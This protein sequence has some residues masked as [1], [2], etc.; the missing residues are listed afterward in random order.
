M[1]RPKSYFKNR[2]GLGELEFNRS[3]A[4]VTG[5]GSGIGRATSLKLTSLGTKVVCVDI[6]LESAQKTAADCGGVSY[7]C[8]TSDAKKMDEVAEKIETEVGEVDI[9]VNNAGVGMTG[10]F[11]DVSLENWEWILN[12]NLNGVINGC[13]SFGPYFVK[14]HRGHV[15]NMSSGLAYFP[16]ATESSYCT[17]KAG[18]L[19]FSQCLRADWYKENVGVSAVCPGVINTNIINTTKFLGER[20]NQ[21]ELDATKKLFSKG[22]SPDVVAKAV[23]RAIRF[24][25][26]VVP[27]GMESAFGF[28]I[29]GIIPMSVQDRI[30][31]SKFMGGI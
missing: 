30:N 9:L 3:I 24:N 4:V 8:D 5:A 11:L 29:R 28:A 31:R 10:R 1:I 14:R 12:I 7:V 16:R 27:A 21:K 13:R 22:H 20:D 23:I 26:A 15:V 2:K 17:T 25:K 19:M 6:N 18:V